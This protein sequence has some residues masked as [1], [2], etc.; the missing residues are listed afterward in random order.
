[1]VPIM[2]LWLPI[3]LSAVFVFIASAIVHTMLSYHHKDFKKASDEDKLRDT[4]RAFNIPPGE[5]LMPYAGS[6]KV[7]GSSEHQEKVKKG[8]TLIMTVWESGNPAMGKSLV[9][10]FIFS[11]MV[12]I[13]AAYVTGRALPAGAEYLAV[14]RFAGC[15]AFVCYTFAHWADYIWF[16]RS[17]GRT[18]R[19]TIDGFVYA[20]LTAG[21]FGW[22]WPG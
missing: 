8:P 20:L 21:A 19:E 22:L 9:Q 5:Y 3:L 2:S 15:T 7:F 13:I 14:F 11:I 16:K 17:F 1:M 4:L 12:S 6:A 18:V 10:W